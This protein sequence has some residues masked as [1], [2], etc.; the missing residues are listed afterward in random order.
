MKKFMYFIFL[1]ALTF[2][3]KLN[4][5][6]KDVTQNFSI[7]DVKACSDA[8]C[9]TEYNET[10][11]N[12]NKTFLIKFNWDYVSSESI[13]SGDYI[14]IPFAT[15]VNTPTT[16]IWSGGSLS[17]TA[18]IDSNGNKIGTISIS[19]TE[20]DRRL[21]II[22][23]DYAVGKNSLSGTFVSAKNITAPYTY[24]D[25]VV[26]LTVGDYKYKMLLKTFK[27]TSL[28]SD[29]PVIYEGN[30]SNDWIQWRTNSP[31][32]TIYQLYRYDEYSELTNDVIYNDLLF[33]MVIPNGSDLKSYQIN[34]R[35]VIPTDIETHYAS[36]YG[37]VYSVNSFFHQITQNTNETYE[38]FKNRVEPFNY[39]IYTDSESNSKVFIVNFGDQ[40]S[41]RITY[42]DALNTTDLKTKLMQINPFLYYDEVASIISKANGTE[43]IVNGKVSLWNLYLTLTY[44][45]VS[46]DTSL[47]QSATWSYKNGLG[48]EKKIPV[49][50]TGV[51]KAS[52]STA[53]VKGTSKLI[54]LDE[55]SKFP[56]S[57]AEFTLQKYNNDSW[58][59]VQS[60]LVTDE[61]GM[62]TVP[63]LEN[64][65]YR[66]VQT[67]YLAHYINDSYKP[68]SDSNLTTELNKFVLNEDGNTTYVTNE[69]ENFTV[70]YKPGEHGNYD[71]K[72]YTVYYGDSL[73]AF[74]PTS[75]LGY[76]SKFNCNR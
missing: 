39:G 75:W 51:L 41:S 30:S 68:Y 4:V 31:T 73:P 44:P 42:N 62:L 27:R 74:T 11:G 23:S 63:N 76:H 43:N 40:P 20:K 9:S 16:A 29:I 58:E 66:Y 55:S 32:N 50:S 24:K 26:P 18:L 49:Q 33:E 8:T 45:K 69:R 54:L 53:E 19:G 10:T 72:V 67:K 35:F 1:L 7:K 60:G 17:S 2:I 64:G 13:E 48:E 52:I 46:V 61:S 25:I 57:G 56:I 6:A 47:T 14:S 3:L 59:D 70:T 15:E 65:E 21:K 28:N 37:F 36:D 34:S 5:Y 71:D 22:F 12:K 38:S